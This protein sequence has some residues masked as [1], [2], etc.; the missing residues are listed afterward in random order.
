MKLTAEIADG[1]LPLGFVPGSMEVYPPLAGGGLP[2]RRQRQELQGL[3]DPG[4][5]SHVKSTDD[6]KSAL[7]RAEAR[8]RAL[9]RR[10]GPSRQE[11]PQRLHGRGAAS[12]TR[13]SASRSSTS[14]GARTRRPRPCP[15]NGST[16]S[17]WSARPPA[18]SSAIAPGR[19]PGIDR[20][21]RSFAPARA[22]EVMAEAARLNP[23]PA[24]FC[25]VCRTVDRYPGCYPSLSHR[26]RY[27]GSR[28]SRNEVRPSAKSGS[29]RAQ[30]LIAILHG[31]HGLSRLPASIA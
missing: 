22:I 6:V 3:R 21:Q 10:H 31:D 13:R 26:P 20:L 1:W 11:L 9:R 4:R 19:I 18:S 25:R 14:P 27:T 30:C 15:T 5:V 24:R 7:A 17:R 23:L 29:C 12:A 2:P 28:F 8:H 16:C